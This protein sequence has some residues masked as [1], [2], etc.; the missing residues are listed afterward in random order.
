MNINVLYFGMLAE[1]TGL[2]GEDWL[3]KEGVT[4]GQLRELLFEKYPQLSEKKFKVAINQ[5]ISD[6]R[7]EITAASVVALL[8]PFAGG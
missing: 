4:V 6:D 5:H 3:V 7:A 1:I 2:A 8:P